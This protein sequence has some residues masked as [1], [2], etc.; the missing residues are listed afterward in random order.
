MSEENQSAVKLDEVPVIKERKRWLL[1]GLP[2]TF[3]TNILDAKS[4]QLHKGFLTTTEDE[5]LLFRIMDISVKRTLLQ[6]LFGLGT[7]IVM[8]SDKTSPNFEIKNIKHIHEFK[9][10]LDER[11]EEERIRM[12]FRS[13]E[14]IDN[15]YDH[16]DGGGY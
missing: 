15:E 1:F 9:K 12:R 5:I 16:N 4:L 10:A 14:F 7:M 11:V 3:T 6:K 2:L 13:G 8:S